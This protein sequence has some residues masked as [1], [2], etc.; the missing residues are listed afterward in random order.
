MLRP[1]SGL[2]PAKNFLRYALVWPVCRQA[3]AATRRHVETVPPWNRVAVSSV[4]LPPSPRAPSRTE[5]IPRRLA[6]RRAP[7][8][9]DPLFFCPLGNLADP[10]GVRLTD[11]PSRWPRARVGSPESILSDFNALRR[12]FR[13]AAS[14]QP[15]VPPARHFVTALLAPVGPFQRVRRQN[16]PQSNCQGGRDL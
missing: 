10:Y 16:L 13:G 12:H 5:D 14:A 3:H 8:L 2:A 4:F 6:D 1:L 7:S 11:S 15:F 9:A